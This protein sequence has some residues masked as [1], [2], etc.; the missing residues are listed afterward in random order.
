MSG[1]IVLDHAVD[2]GLVFVSH[3]R[4]DRS[5]TLRL[6]RR[7]RDAGLRTWICGPELH[8]PAWQDTVFPQIELCGMVVVVSSAHADAADGVRHEIA[9]AELLGKPVVRLGADETWPRSLPHRQYKARG[10]RRVNDD[11]EFAA[12]RGATRVFP[13]RRQG[14]VDER[15]TLQLQP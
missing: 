12:H 5:S 3:S 7:L 1:S 15:L 4:R 2:P 8:S 14:H 10:V 6:M 11:A 13:E 9:Y